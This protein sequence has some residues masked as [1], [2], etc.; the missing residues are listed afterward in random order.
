[1]AL[2]GILAGEVDEL[3]DV[4]GFVFAGGCSGCF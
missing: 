4:V 1:V 3:V 2:R